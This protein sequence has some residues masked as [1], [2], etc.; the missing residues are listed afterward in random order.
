MAV[1]MAGRS[2]PAARHVNATA[3]RARLPGNAPDRT[4][5]YFAFSASAFTSSSAAAKRLFEQRHRFG[6]GA[7]DQ[8]AEFLEVRHRTFVSRL[9]ELGLLRGLRLRPLGGGKRAHRLGHFGKRLLHDL[10][11]PACDRLRALERYLVGG[12]QGFEVAAICRCERLEIGHR[13]QL[14]VSEIAG[15]VEIGTRGGVLGGFGTGGHGQ[16]LFS[17]RTTGVAG[18]AKIIA[19]R[20]ATWA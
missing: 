19:E 4:S 5:G 14:E 10:H 2:R 20:E 3:R 6:V 17:A 13:R 11:V 15:E 1:D 7:L 12:R 16:L 8:V 9:G 18:D